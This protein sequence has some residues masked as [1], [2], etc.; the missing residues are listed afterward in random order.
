LDL[1]NAILNAYGEVFDMRKES[2]EDSVEYIFTRGKANISYAVR[3]S[4]GWQSSSG[5]K[6]SNDITCLF[7]LKDEKVELERAASLL[8][9]TF[10]SH[11]IDHRPESDAKFGVWLKGGENDRDLQGLELLRKLNVV[12]EDAAKWFQVM[13]YG[14]YQY[15]QFTP[16]E[17]QE[18]FPE[19]SEPY[20]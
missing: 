8:K 10:K 6:W 4:D 14:G 13:I 15:K 20:R 19:H 12:P 5:E 2:D 18:M 11:L 1:S 16:A 7:A 3:G 17:L 9:H